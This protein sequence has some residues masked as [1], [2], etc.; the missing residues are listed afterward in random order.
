MGGTNDPENLVEVTIEQHAALHKQ[1]WE[2]LG[3]WQDEIAW[4]T[5]SGQ[6]TRAEAIKMIQSRPKSE[7]TKQKMRKPKSEEHKR[8]MRQPRTEEHKRNISKS[9][10]GKKAKGRQLEILRQ[11]AQLNKIRLRSEEFREKMRL[12]NLENWRKRK[13]NSFAE[14]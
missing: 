4:K 1:L 6:I 2:D 8:N 7:E 11:N 14:Q 12:V 3:Y 9:K 5:L 13:E 10:I